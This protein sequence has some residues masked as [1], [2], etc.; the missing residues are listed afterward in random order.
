MAVCPNCGTENNNK[1]KRCNQCGNTLPKKQKCIAS[2]VLLSICCIIYLIQI[3]FYHRWQVIVYFNIQEIFWF[4]IDW[5]VIFSFVVGLVLLFS[6]IFSKGKKYH[7]IVT[8]A[9]LT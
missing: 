9:F 6:L 7:S 4:F 2:C 5:T 8:T 3:I 1:D